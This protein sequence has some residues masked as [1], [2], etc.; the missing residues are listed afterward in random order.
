MQSANLAKKILS[1]HN[2]NQFLGDSDCFLASNRRYFWHM[3]MK[4]YFSNRVTIR[5]YE[6]KKIPKETID[7]ILEKAMRAPTCGNMQL[8]SVVV[9]QDAAR[10]KEL[11]QYHFN[12]PAATGCDTILTVCADFKRFCQWCEASGARPGY[13]NFH[14]FIMALTDA[15][16]Y[17]QQIVT[18]AEMNGLGTCYLGTVNYNAKEISDFL[19]LPDHVV[20]V[21]SISLGYPAETDGQP[22]RLPLKAIVH[23]EKYRDDTISD[24]KE[25]FKAKDEDPENQVFIKENDK[26]SLAEVFTDIRYPK[27]TNEKV[28][29]S[30]INLLKEKGFMTE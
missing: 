5:K 7:S 2:P 28:S 26:R 23:E 14:S 19:N 12:Q 27:S 17:A 22:D 9:T 8:Y 21:A 16:I 3:E 11:A 20:P 13:S 24:T 30:F 25:F 1:L 10:K 18:I 29:V 6:D 4:D 15:V